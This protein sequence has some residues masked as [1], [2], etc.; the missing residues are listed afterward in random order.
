MDWKKI[1]G[2]QNFNFLDEI[3][4]SQRHP[5]I[6][7]RSFMQ[8]FRHFPGLSLSTVFPLYVD[9]WSQK[10]GEMDERGLSSINIYSSAEKKIPLS[11]KKEETLKSKQESCNLVLHK[12]RQYWTRY[13]Q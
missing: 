4:I 6:F 13:K 9:F 5:I 8:W 2:K 7:L 1:N 10:H 12:H 3:T 11:L